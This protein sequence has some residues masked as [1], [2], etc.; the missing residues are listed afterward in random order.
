MRR[1]RLCGAKF[2]LSDENGKEI[3]CVQTDVNGEA[4][5]DGLPYG[6]YFLTE[7][8]PPDGYAR[9]EKRIEIALSENCPDRLVEI[10]G[11]RRCGSIKIIRFGSG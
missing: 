3:M 9:Y 4:F 10:I 1:T 7:C 5:I 11:A 6:K 8:E 2:V